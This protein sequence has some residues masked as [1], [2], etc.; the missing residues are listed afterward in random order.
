MWGIFIGLGLGVLEVL[1]LKKLIAMMTADK[2][3]TAIAVPLTIAKLALI[4]VV[5]W[6]MARFISL[7]AMIWCAAGVA[8]AMIGIPVVTGIL[9]IKKYRQSG[10]E[11]K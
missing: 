2:R 8:A 11:Q 9:T 5:L 7:E 6:L 4:L 3:N 1:F 10:G